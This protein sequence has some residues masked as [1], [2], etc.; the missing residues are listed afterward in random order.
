MRVRVRVSDACLLAQVREARL[1]Q[2]Q[3]EQRDGRLDRVRI[4]VRVR[5]WV[6]VRVATQL[7]QAR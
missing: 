5:V 1:D 4:R 3:D 6:G 7:A 2:P